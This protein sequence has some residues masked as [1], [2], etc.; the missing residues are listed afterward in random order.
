MDSQGLVLPTVRCNSPPVLLEQI[1][2]LKAR[3]SELEN[4]LHDC[5]KNLRDS[6]EAARE[7]MSENLFRSKIKKNRKRD[8]RF[9]ENFIRRGS[10]DETFTSSVVDTKLFPRSKRVQ[11]AM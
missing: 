3:V 2:E 11:S 8:R 4:K 1:K 9:D 7:L 5:E 10:F 6:E